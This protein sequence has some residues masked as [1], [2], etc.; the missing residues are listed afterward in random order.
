LLVTSREQVPVP[1]QPPPLQPVKVEPEDGVAVRVILVPEVMFDCVQTD[2]QLMDPPV[3]VPVPA[4]NKLTER[5]YDEPVPVVV[6]GV[7][8][9]K[10]GA[11]L[12]G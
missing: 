2:P 10:G 1:L 4:P 7:I 5:E 12:L 8:G 3:T 9:D 6:I 11:K